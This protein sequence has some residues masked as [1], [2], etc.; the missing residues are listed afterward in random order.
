MKLAPL[1]I[2]VILALSGGSALAQNLRFL[3]RSP[4][5]YFDDQ[6]WALLKQATRDALDNSPDGATTSWENPKTGHKGTVTPLKTYE[7]SG[8]TCRTVRFSSE[9]A[10]LTGTS[11]HSLCKK[12]DRWRIAQ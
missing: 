11:T 5:A 9:A 12:A 1:L 8:M 7:D 6:D 4:A 10:D 2:S 3:E